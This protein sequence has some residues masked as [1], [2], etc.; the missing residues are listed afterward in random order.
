MRNN[1]LNSIGHQPD[2][3][4]HQMCRDAL[5]IRDH[6][7]RPGEAGLDGVG[8]SLSRDGGGRSQLYFCCIIISCKS[9]NVTNMIDRDDDYDGDDENDDDV[10]LIM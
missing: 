6:I 3:F 8:N 9:T 7:P 4:G 1:V 5:H 10:M 2:Q